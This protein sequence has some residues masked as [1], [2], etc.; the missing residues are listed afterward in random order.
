MF[1]EVVA[2]RSRDAYIRSYCRSEGCVQDP[3]RAP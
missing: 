1:R 3:L 2:E